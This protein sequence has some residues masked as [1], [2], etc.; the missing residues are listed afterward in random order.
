MKGRFPS[1]D[2]DSIKNSYS[3]IEKIEKNILR[4]M[5]RLVS[6][7]LLWNNHLRIMTISTPEITSSCEYNSC[8]LAWIVYKS[9][10]LETGE[11]HISDKIY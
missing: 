7:N 4:N 9:A 11:Y 1:T 8:N 5:S 6:H 3:S 10:F 2:R